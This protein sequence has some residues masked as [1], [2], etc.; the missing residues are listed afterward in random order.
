MGVIKRQGIKTSIVSYIGVAIG[1]FNT[2]WLFPK[3]LPSHVI[4]LISILTNIS[5]IIAPLSQLGVNGIIIKYYPHFKNK[6]EE[7]KSFNFFILLIPIVGFT[8]AMVLLYFSRTIIIDNFIES[9]PLIVDY[10]FLLVPFSFVLVGQNVTATLARAQFRTTIPKLFNDVVFRILMFIVVIAYTL[11]KVDLIYLLIGVI[12]SYLIAL[13]L[14]IFYLRQLT[15]F[16]I[17]L[18]LKHIK[19]IYKSAL[20]YGMF[21]IFNGLAAIIITKI[22]SWM[23]ASI[24]DLRNTGIYAIA[25][26]IGLVIEMPKRS[27]NLISLPV[28]GDAMKNNDMQAVQTLYTKSSLIQLVLGSILLTCV[29]VNI[30]D[31]FML[32]PNSLVFI[33]GKYVVLFIGLGVLFDMSTGINSEIMIM[34]KHYRWNLYII[35]F[36][37]FLATINNLLLIPVYGITGAA[38]A[39]AVTLF[40]FN[41]TKYVVLK[42]KLNI[43]PFSIKSLYALLLGGFFMTLGLLLPDSPF[44]LLNII[45]K[46]CILITLYVVAVYK[47]QLSKDISS[48]IDSGINRVKGFLKKMK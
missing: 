4:G 19:P 25:L 37:I 42:I 24:L 3:F 34:S 5:L 33:E 32:I 26:F 23:I 48:M 20:Q 6:K 28:V 27:L 7:L 46:S 10:L 41:A 14:N 35:V 38:L 45:Y 22:D 17:K 9:S 2:L 11:L 31:L 12:S 36:L 21:I 18:S 44:P 1:A 39:T 13:V 40:I 43:Q 47:L 15:S 8:I 29:W 30:D 16:Q